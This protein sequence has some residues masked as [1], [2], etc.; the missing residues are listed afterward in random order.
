MPLRMPVTGKARLVIVINGSSYLLRRAGPVAW[1]LNRMNTDGTVSDSW[2]V[3]V[4]PHGPECDCPDF[5]WC[6]EGLDQK[7]CKHVAGLRAVGLLETI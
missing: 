1:R 4:S 3:Q 5:V 6:R 2:T 7:G